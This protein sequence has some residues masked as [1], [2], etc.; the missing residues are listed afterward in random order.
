MKSITS[1]Q[2]QCPKEHKFT[3]GATIINTAHKIFELLLKADAARGYKR[4]G[5][6]TEASLELD[7]L[8]IFIRLAKDTHAMSD[9]QYIHL[10]GQLN[11][12]GKMLGGWIASC[13]DTK[14]HA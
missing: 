1:W 6:L 4:T 8:K 11:E 12:I 5:F 14:K 7:L 10:Q 2:T 3:I 13:F 9:K